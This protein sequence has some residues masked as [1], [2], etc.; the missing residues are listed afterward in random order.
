M[1][2]PVVLKTPIYYIYIWAEE[3][4]RPLSATSIALEDIFRIT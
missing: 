1:L 2:I 4:Q 3:T